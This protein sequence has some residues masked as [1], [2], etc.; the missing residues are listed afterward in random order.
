M[1]IAMDWTT[2]LQAGNQ[3]EMIEPSEYVEVA[4]VPAPAID[5]MPGDLG[6]YLSAVFSEGEHVA[7]CT[8]ANTE[9]GVGR[10]S[11]DLTAGEITK[12]LKSGKPMAEI[13]G[14]IGEH[15]AWIGINPLDGHGA[16]DANISQYR[17]AI[18][19]SDDGELG[20]QLSILR[21]LR[22]PCSA[23]IHSGGRSI[24]AIV[25]IDAVNRQEYRTRVDFLYQVVAKAGLQVDGKHRYPSRLTRMPGVP[26]GIEAQ[27]LIPYESKFATWEEW[28]EHM[29]D[30][31]DE[32]PDIESLADTRDNP[33][34]RDAEIIKGVLRKGHKG[35]MSGPSKAGKSWALQQL[36]ISVAEG[37]PW[38]GFPVVQGRVLYVNCELARASAIWRFHQ[39]YDAIGIKKASMDNIDIWNI[40][41]AATG[42]SKLAPKLIRRAKERDGY[43]IIILDPLYKVEEGDENA[44]HVM[45]SLFNLFEVVAMKTGA[46][47]VYAH[48]HSKGDQGG[49]KAGDRGSGS[50][51][52]LRDPDALLDLTE[53]ILPDARRKQLTNRVQI[54]HLSRLAME[55][56]V[57]PVDGDAAESAE[58]MVF[59]L[60]GRIPDDDLDAAMTAGAEVARLM[61]GFRLE[62]TLRE[63]PKFKPRHT[64]FRFPIHIDDA[65][66]YHLLADAKAAGEEPPWMQAQRDR[67]KTAKERKQSKTEELDAAITAA[68]GPGATTEAVAT[69][70]GASE[71]TIRRRIEKSGKWSVIDGKIQKRGKGKVVL[72]L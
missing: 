7:I 51:V 38:M 21:G 45:T 6:R 49:K 1:V 67:E 56:G 55:S 19:Q 62:G 58:G 15:G 20:H 35:L 5:S 72:D 70:L 64:W 10:I 41:A 44:A 46:A 3:Q 27:Y 66:T 37:R 26:R 13:I 48:H 29:E 40:R 8:D 14:D 4:E 69:G 36:C 9:G 23:V 30:L 68:G 17:H 34:E 24:H 52:I 33:P 12:A 53:L 18:I 22:L 31:H 71:K 2:T 61:E 57:N 43:S 47:L 32:L 25:K 59:G 39:L 42:M 11:H 16:R 60:K 28:Q 65:T 50:G 54:E 63:F